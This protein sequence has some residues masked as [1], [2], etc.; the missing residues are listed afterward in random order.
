MSFAFS[1]PPNGD[2]WSAAGD[3]RTV[4]A[5]DLDGGDVSVVRRGAN[6]STEVGVR[7]AS[8]RFEVRSMGGIA[9]VERR[10]GDVGVPEDE[11]AE[12]CPTCG[13]TGVLPGHI[14]CPTCDGTGRVDDHDEDDVAR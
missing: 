14:E 12:P 1:V 9:V 7:G 8:G 13:G 11:D 6:R 4:T 10:Q 5:V 2:V 3:E